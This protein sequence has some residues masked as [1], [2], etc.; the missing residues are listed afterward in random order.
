MNSSSAEGLS[1]HDR[2]ALTNLY[3][4]DSDSEGSNED[5]QLS[6]QNYGYPDILDNESPF[7]DHS[8]ANREILTPQGSHD[9]FEDDDPI[10]YQVENEE[11]QPNVDNIRPSFDS[12]WLLNLPETE[13][14]FYFYVLT[15]FID[16]SK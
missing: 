2:E 7:D 12:N 11:Q 1:S 9:S 6:D 4:N 5:G 3:M 16:Q 14:W 13:K 8:L 15:Q 10:E